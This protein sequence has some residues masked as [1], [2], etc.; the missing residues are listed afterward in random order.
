MRFLKLF[1]VLFVLSGPVFADDAKTVLPVDEG[2][3]DPDFFAFRR[4]LIKAA[5]AHNADFIKS[6][7]APDI[8][9]SFGPD[10][11]LEEF[12]KKSDLENPESVFYDDLLN[13]LLN[14]GSMSE[15]GSFCGPYTFNSD[16]IE[17]PYEEVMVLSGDVPIY[18]STKPGAAIIDRSSF[19]ILKLNRDV[20]EVENG[21]TGVL[22]PAGKAGFIQEALVRNGVDYRACFA[23]NAGGQYK[24]N[25]FIAGD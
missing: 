15:Q 1:L 9:H 20:H 16:K 23:K 7:V 11:G 10:G 8:K 17:D 21:W 12:Y 2:A 4:E 6:I 13:V 22:T 5:I 19:G 25:M 24:M 18:E 14:G 3:K